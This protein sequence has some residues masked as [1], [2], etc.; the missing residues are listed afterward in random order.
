[1]KTDET[2]T[3]RMALV[4]MRLAARLLPPA[5]ADWARAMLGEIY[6]MN[7][8]TQALVWA[9]SCITA[10]LTMRIKAMIIGN[11]KISRWVLTPELLFCFTP[12]TLA[13]YD[14]IFGTSG[15]IQLN[16]EIV[17]RYFLNSTTGTIALIIMVTLSVLGIFGPLGLVIAIRTIAQGRC[18]TDKRLLIALCTMP[19]L[20]G[21]IHFTS[22]LLMGTSIKF[23]HWAGLILV[24][25]LPALGAVH[26]RY[27]SPSVSGFTAQA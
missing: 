16:P 1:M 3:Q 27:L 6:H 19:V 9:V 14:S 15:I 20:L 8:D 7:Q 5:R 18:L 12:L 17:Q 13:W 24:S 23:D 21:A 22:W 10:S 2:K 25:L 11:L 4:L 26:M